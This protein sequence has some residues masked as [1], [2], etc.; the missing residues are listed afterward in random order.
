MCS[1]SSLCLDKEVAHWPGHL[2][3][4]E[5]KTQE[6]LWDLERVH[7]MHINLHTQKFIH[8]CIMVHVTIMVNIVKYTIVTHTKY[9]ILLLQSTISDRYIYSQ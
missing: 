2:A 7:N 8:F 9:I 4:V 5:K 6:E 1:F 3:T